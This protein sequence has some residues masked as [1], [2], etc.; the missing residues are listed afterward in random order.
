MDDKKLTGAVF[1]DLSKAFDTVS[2]AK[3]ISKL[4]SFGILG[5]E[6]HWITDYLFNRLQI[7]S[8]KGSLSSEA[9]VTCGV[10]QGS[11]I[12]PLLF[13]LLL[14]DLPDQ[15]EHCSCVK[16]ADDT[17]LYMGDKDVNNITKNLEFIFFE[18]S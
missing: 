2:H 12:G 4:P 17:V 18:P 14:N 9:S 15:L 11:I 6:K 13:I 3:I 7:V 16:Y 10:P 1:I 8:Y 5:V